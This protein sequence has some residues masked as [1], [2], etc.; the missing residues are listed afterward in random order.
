[1]LKE[2]HE[3]ETVYTSKDQHILDQGTRHIVAFN[4]HGMFRPR[5]LNIIGRC[6]FPIAL[7]SQKPCQ[8]KQKQPWLPKAFARNLHYIWRPV[9]LRGA[10]CTKSRLGVLTPFPI[11]LTRVSVALARV[12]LGV[13]KCRYI[14]NT[15][16]AIH[17][18][19]LH[20]ANMPSN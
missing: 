13:R 19:I 20:G 3:A 14:Y 18:V 4:F 12:W 16:M 9:M 2:D 15:A 6:C 17:F 1:M 8:Q 10:A 5:T 7:A 11:D